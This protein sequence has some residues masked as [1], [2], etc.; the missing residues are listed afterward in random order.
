ME[1]HLGL[2]AIGIFA[3]A[4]KFPGILS[5]ISSIF[6]SA[7]QISVLEEFGE[8]GYY[9]FFNRVLRLLTVSCFFVFFVITICSK[10]IITVL[11]TNSFYDAWQYIPILTLGIIFSNLS[12]FIG[13]NFSAIRKSKYYF[14]SSLYGAV[15]S[16]I[17]N[18]ILIPS[19]GILGAAIVVPISFLVMTISRVAYGWKYVRIKGII[20]YIMMLIIAVLL[21]VTILYVQ[22]G[23]IKIILITFLFI[24]FTAINYDLRKDVL[25]IFRL[26]KKVI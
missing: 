6:V 12:G 8:K 4:S 10:I 26:V 15:I 16:V 19:L 25:L 24:F 22:T 9:V 13:S 11:A 18:I 23:A 20:N 21:I 5:I 7:W 1:H 3:V 2:H 17:S 14:F